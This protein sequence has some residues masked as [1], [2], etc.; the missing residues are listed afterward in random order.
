[1]SSYRDLEVYRLAHELGVLVH[2]FTLRLPR[3]EQTEIGRQLRRAALSISANIVEAYGRRHYKADFIRFLVIA[4]ASCDE[5]V[6]WLRYLGECHTELVEEAGELQKKCEMLG[7]KLSAF[8]ASVERKHQSGTPTVAELEEF[9]GEEP[10][11]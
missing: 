2:R 10:V 8:I 11:F 3:F 4:H 9:Y 1:M 7:R 6:E 5:S